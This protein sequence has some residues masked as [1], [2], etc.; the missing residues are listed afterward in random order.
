MAGGGDLDLRQGPTPRHSFIA[1]FLADVLKQV[2]A[3]CTAGTKVLDICELG[4]KLL[5]EETS[6][7]YKREKELKK[8][9]KYTRNLRRQHSYTRVFPEH[10]RL[11]T[12]VKQWVAETQ[13]QRQFL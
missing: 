6:K 12:I 4:D 1:R 2:V 10:F 13:T 9:E 8:G 7:V 3:K 11:R 5:T